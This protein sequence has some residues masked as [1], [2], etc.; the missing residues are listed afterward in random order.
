[1]QD[2]YQEN[3]YK[4]RYINPLNCKIGLDKL[5]YIWTAFFCLIKTANL[6]KGAKVLDFGCG[7]GNYVKILR[8]LGMLAYGVDSSPAAK[9]NSV[10]PQ[11][12]FHHHKLKKTNYANSYFDLVFSNEVLEHLNENELD[13]YLN[14]LCRISKGTMIHMVGVQ[15]KGKAVTEDKTHYLIKNEDWWKK[16]FLQHGFSVKK[17]NLLY[18]SSPKCGL[19]IKKG[20][21]L[22]KKS[23]T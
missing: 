14:E 2:Q 12:C 5:Y 21:F 18:F 4:T 17:G 23:K 3:Y 13:F 22:L 9:K 8:K 7:I 10:I 1:M 15:E 19:G 16:K 6:H 20:Y 11:F